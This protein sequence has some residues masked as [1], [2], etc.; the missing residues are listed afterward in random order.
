MQMKREAERRAARRNLVAGLLAGLI[1]ATVVGAYAKTTFTK[2]VTGQPATAAGVN[3]AHQDLATAIDNL[4]AKVAALKGERDCPAGYT[5]DTTAAGITLCRRGKD[6]MVKTGTFWIDRYEISVVNPVMYAS[7]SCN[8]TGTVY[9]VSGDDFPATFPDSG[10]F[11]APLHACSVKAAMPSAA[12]TWFQAA[13]AC[14]LAG[15]RLCTNA[16]WQVAALGT[17]DDSAL[18]N[19]KSSAKTAAGAR[20]KCVSTW[21]AFDMVGNV[22]EW[23]AD[24]GQTGKSSATFASATMATPWGSGY[25]DGQDATWNLNGEAHAISGYTTGSPAAVA[26]GGTWTLDA[27]AGVFAL[28]WNL[29]PKYRSSTT[30]GRCCK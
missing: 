4:E 7:G 2:M 25:G 14:E 8:G 16:E 26:R 5:R 15:K 17:P 22:W 12:M 20:A 21:G 3:Q 24:W 1:L 13:V 11:S 19:T 30:G 29:S 6:E 23:A 27:S 18:C 10:S 28:A 9:G